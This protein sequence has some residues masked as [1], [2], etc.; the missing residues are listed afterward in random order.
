[1]FTEKEVQKVKV[2][3]VSQE[4]ESII[5]VTSE[6]SSWTGDALEASASFT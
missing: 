2:Q 4:E 1:V 6:E 5:N 3:E